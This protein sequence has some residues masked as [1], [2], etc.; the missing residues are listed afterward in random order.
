ADGVSIVFYTFIMTDELIEQY[1]VYPIFFFIILRP[2]RSTLFP[3]TT[4]FRSTPLNLA[5]GLQKNGVNI[6]GTS[7]QN[8]EIAEDRKFF[9][10][11]LRQLNV[12]QPPNGV[13]TNEAEA[14]A[15]AKKLD[16]PVLVRPSF[17]LGGR[18]MQIVFSDAE[19]RHYMR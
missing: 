11:M 6:I 18:A 15:V 13:A 19:L 10:A 14:L 7:P 16:Y 12:P 4:L 8:I 2:T 17:V 5:L 3:Y 9:A 1:Y